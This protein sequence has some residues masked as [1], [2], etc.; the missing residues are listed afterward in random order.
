[1]YCCRKTSKWGNEIQYD[2]REKSYKKGMRNT[3]IDILKSIACICVLLGHVIS[4]IQKANFTV[5]PLLYHLCRYIYLFH[6]PCFFFASGYLYANKQF[7]NMKEYIRFVCKKFITLGIPYLAC[8]VFYVFF[9]S[10][11]SSEMN[12]NT[13]YTLIYLF[14]IW[15]SPVAQYW[16][17]YALL[18]MFIIVPV[19]EI[20]FGRNN[21]IYIWIGF[22]ML[23]FLVHSNILCISFVAQYSYLFYMGVV[24]HELYKNRMKNDLSRMSSSFRGR[25]FCIGGIT[26]YL[27]YAVAV[28]LLPAEADYLLRIIITPLLVLIMLGESFAISE[29]KNC[30]YTFLLWLSKYTL[31]VYLFHTCFSG[32][33][34]ILLRRLGIT[35]CW[36]LT[37]AGITVGF[38]GPVL[39]AKIMRKNPVLK[40]WIEPLD[41]IKDIK[42]R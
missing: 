7:V 30:I 5:S 15:K 4:G 9:S 31:Y 12:P 6:V 25:V 20:I 32:T 27:I 29:R 26:L 37:I 38:V 21:K 24:F 16:Y 40:F 1:M 41:S 11:F 10:F 35:N 2:S 39:L 8:S 13:S 19:V 42:N 36:F 14:N 3:F 23:A 22:I 17:L 28:N 34:R 33:M 18:E